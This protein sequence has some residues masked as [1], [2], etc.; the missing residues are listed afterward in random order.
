[1]PSVLARRRPDILAAEDRLHAA[2]AA[3]GVAVA[4]RLPTITLSADIGSEAGQIGKLFG[5]GGGLWSYGASTSE[6]L[7]DAGALADQEDAARD[8][9]LGAVATYKKTVLAA[10]QDVA[11][12]L[13]ALQSDAD[14]LNAK[15]AADAAAQQ[16]LDLVKSQFGAGAVTIAELLNAQQAAAQAKIALVQARAQRYADSAALLAALG[17]GWWNRPYPDPETSTAQT[18]PQGDSQ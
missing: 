11:N 8:T 2:S 7:F 6:T 15:M 18:E 13:H 14:S 1:V 17:G 12:A 9:F 5:P 16:S 10:Y 3:I 4:N